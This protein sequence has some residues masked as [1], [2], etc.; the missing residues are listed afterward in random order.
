MRVNLDVWLRIASNLRI[1]NQEQNKITPLPLTPVQREWMETVNDNRLSICLKARQIYISTASQ[2][3]VLGWAL[4]NPGL[5]ASI[6]L[7]DHDKAKR[8]IRIMSGWCSQ[9]GIEHE[10]NAKEVRLWN[11][12]FINAYSALSRRSNAFSGTARGTSAQLLYFSELA[13]YAEAEASFSAATS[14][15]SPD[16]KI[17][18][19]STSTGKNSLFHRLYNAP[20]WVP[21][22]W[23]IESHGPYQSST[24]LTPEQQIKYQELGFKS[25][26][27]AAFFHDKLTNLFTGDKNRCLMEYPVL[28]EHAWT[29]LEGRFIETDNL[30]LKEY[31]PHQTIRPMRVFHKPTVQ[32]R[33]I[34]GYDPSAGSGLDEAAISV[35]DRYTGRLEATWTSNQLDADAQVAILKQI[36]DFYAHPADLPK[37]G[38]P[39]ESYVETIIIENNGIGGGIAPFMRKAGLPVYEATTIG[40]D[41]DYSK[42]LNFLLVKRDVEIG[43]LSGDEAFRDECIGL[44]RQ[45]DGKFTGKDDLIASVGFCLAYMQRHPRTPPKSQINRNTHFD[46]EHAYKARTSVRAF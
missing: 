19:E 9:L 38:D 4:V 14:S 29:S 32:T 11:G 25:L 1:P 17:I 33:Y 18:V 40:G 43:R 23:G 34:I 37:W 36:H 28:E 6:F 31:E 8:V 15:G 12:A 45:A 27:H 5:T 21:K 10:S 2:L 30:Q 46:M 42:Y 16:A 22:F 26:T 44:C 35:I 24:Q 20:G 7:D 3:Y 39:K 41:K 13:F